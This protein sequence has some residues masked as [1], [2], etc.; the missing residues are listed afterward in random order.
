MLK[1]I[2]RKFPISKRQRCIAHKMRNII[3]KLPREAQGRIKNEVHQI[4]YAYDHVEAE[5]RAA[6]FVKKYSDK[7]PEMV[8]CFM[9]DLQAC[10]EHL[11]FPESH[12]K[13]IRTTNLIERTFVEEKRR[14]KIIPTHQNEK[15][16]MNLVFGVL[17]RVSYKWNK[18][19]ISPL[20]KSLLLKIRN[21]MT[22]YNIHNNDF[23]SYEG[24]A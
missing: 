10:L 15:G 7:Y 20:D 24:A 3:G 21:I 13:F 22:P 23:V 16:M 14:T 5:T 8:R 4:Y 17:I 19:N 2:T 1:A 12:R 9:E 6:E 11:K 18:M